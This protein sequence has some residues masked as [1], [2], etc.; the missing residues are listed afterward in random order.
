LLAGVIAAASVS[1]GVAA[2]VVAAAP[3]STVVASAV[4]P[5]WYKTTPA[6]GVGYV[7]GVAACVAAGYYGTKLVMQ[8]K[9]E[10]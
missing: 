3:G 5:V 1:A 10:A 8:M 4:K 9:Q 7:A 2:P 6:K